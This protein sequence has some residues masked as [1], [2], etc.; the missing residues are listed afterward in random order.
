MGREMLLYS[1][2]D[3]DMSFEEFVD[4]I[5]NG[6]SGLV[7][8]K[9]IQDPIGKS[10]SNPIWGNIYLY[11][12]GQI[13]QEPQVGLYK[14]Y[15]WERPDSAYAEKLWSVLGKIMLDKCRVADIDII[16]DRIN[17]GPAVLSY[18]IMD[19]SYE[20]LTNLNSIAFR[21]FDRQELKKFGGYMKIENLLEFIKLEVDNADNFKEIEQC[22]IETILLDSITNNADRHLDNWALIRDKNT[23]K[24]SLGLFD[25]SLSFIDMDAHAINSLNGWTSSYLL[26]DSPEKRKRFMKGDNGEKLV[27]YIST[28]YT[29]YFEEFSQKFQNRIG[30]FNE[31]LDMETGGIVPSVVKMNFGIKINKLNELSYKNKEGDEYGR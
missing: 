25:H 20:D 13:A 27:K 2:E 24:Y 21:K 15:D 7:F 28:N 22:I 29:E 12:N 4:R 11:E 5:P 6:Y 18:R 1:E 10:G 23:N 16:N 19:N 8:N 26:I 31:K 30:I 14:S 3:S 9:I 17:G